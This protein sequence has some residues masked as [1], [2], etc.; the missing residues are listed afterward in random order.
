MGP[1]RIVVDL[2]RLRGRFGED[3]AYGGLQRYL[4]R[5]DAGPGELLSMASALDVRGPM[6]R[7]LN[8]AMA[9]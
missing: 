3:L 2:M 5:R 7:A 4:R 9:R 1:T 8:I 6:Q